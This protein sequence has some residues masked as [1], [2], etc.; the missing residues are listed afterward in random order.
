M[1][2]QPA[3]SR[4]Y[5]IF[6]HNNP[7]V[8]YAALALC[9]ALLI[10]KHL[11]KAKAV[12]LVTDQG[13]LRWLKMNHP[14]DHISHAFDHIIVTD[15][16]KN[17]ANDRRFQDTRYSSFKAAYNN[18][19]RPNVLQY[20][21][22]DETVLLDADYLM[23]DDSMDMVWGSIEDFMCNRKTCD[24][25]HCHNGFGFDNR[26]NDMSIPLYW[27]TAIYFKKTDHSRL[28]FDLMEFV[29][30][31]YSY[32]Q[33][34]YRFMSSSYY[35]NDF[36]LSIAIHV[37]NNLMEYGSIANLPIDHILFSMEHDE[38]H[39]FSDGRCLITSEPSQGDF[40]LHDVSMNVHMMNK[41]AVLRHAKEIIGYATC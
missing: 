31:N 24:L 14:A 35:R 11:K 34:L 39:R 40:R 7:S 20:S 1:T 41:R 18:L 17:L 28:I 21:P 5:V 3:G 13:S 30:E 25:D 10:K 23:L 2:D 27:A 22:F 6:A 33:Y 15:I 32:Y 38:L 37:A 9:N 4:G 26:F 19:N 16:D 12:A 8:D 36:A 29:R